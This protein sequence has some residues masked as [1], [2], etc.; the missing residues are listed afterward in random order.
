MQWQVGDEM[1]ILEGDVWVDRGNGPVHLVGP[2][3]YSDPNSF[4]DGGSSER[5]E[6]GCV[7]IRWTNGA[8]HLVLPPI[9]D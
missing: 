4:V 7:A 9:R 5:S 6:N 2:S 3:Y 1:F 8:D